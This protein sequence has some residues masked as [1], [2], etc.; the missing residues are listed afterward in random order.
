MLIIDCIYDIINKKKGVY[1]VMT[2]LDLYCYIQMA[3][4][5]RPALQKDG[6]T[7]FAYLECVDLEFFVLT[8]GHGNKVGAVIPSSVDV[9][10]YVIDFY[11]GNGYMSK[12]LKSGI[13]QEMYPDCVNASIT[14][15]DSLEMTQKRYALAQIGGFHITNEDDVLECFANPAKYFDDMCVYDEDTECW[16][17][18]CVDLDDWEACELCNL[19]DNEQNMNM[20][21]SVYLLKQAI[22]RLYYFGGRALTKMTKKYMVGL[23]R[24]TMCVSSLIDE[25]VSDKKL[26]KYYDVAFY[27]RIKLSKDIEDEL[28]QYIQKIRQNEVTENITYYIG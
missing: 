21:A 6:T 18:E 22:G 12:F 23:E 7:Y 4:L 26:K 14:I 25:T 24:L 27:P 16:H 9:Y 2:N 1:K 15:A 19:D 11:R 17:D 13:L 28:E 3:K 10:L 8:D 20:L 5:H